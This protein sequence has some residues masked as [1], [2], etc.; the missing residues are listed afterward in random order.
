MGLLSGGV[1]INNPFERL[2]L[3]NAG[4]FPLQFTILKEGKGRHT[5]DLKKIGNNWIFVHINLD[6]PRP[7]PELAFQFLQYRLHHFTGPAPVG[8]KVY[9]R[10]RFTLHQIRKI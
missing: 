4:L 9:Q 5:L 8:I 10:W 7:A 3:H 6:D 2:D 1:L